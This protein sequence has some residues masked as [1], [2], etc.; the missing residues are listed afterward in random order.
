MC[1]AKLERTRNPLHIF[2]RNPDLQ[3]I[4]TQQK[5]S[6]SSQTE[7]AVCFQSWSTF[8]KG[9]EGHQTQQQAALCS[10]F[11]SFFATRQQEVSRVTAEF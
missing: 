11:T 3:R 10:V 6:T 8:S 7:C 2:N 1:H 4:S 9:D 5:D